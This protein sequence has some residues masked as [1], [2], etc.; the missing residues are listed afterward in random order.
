MAYTGNDFSLA[1]EQVQDTVL[2]IYNNANKAQLSND[3]IVKELLDLDLDQISEF[4]LCFLE[5]GS[6]AGPE[7]VIGVHP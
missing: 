2:K 7:S 5:R 6:L 3:I 4:A 1:F